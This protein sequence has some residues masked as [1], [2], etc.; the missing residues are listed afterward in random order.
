MDIN[1]NHCEFIYWGYNWFGQQCESEK[2]ISGK[3]CELHS[4]YNDVV[5]VDQYRRCKFVYANSPKIGVKCERKCHNRLD[6][7]RIH[8]ETCKHGRRKAYCRK[9]NNIPF[10]RKKQKQ[11]NLFDAAEILSKLDNS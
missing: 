10:Y 2:T 8:K 9:C 3:F 6:Y 11:L 4:H 1:T 5:Y 7:C